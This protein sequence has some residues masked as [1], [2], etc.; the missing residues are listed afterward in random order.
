[1][2]P[3]HA[4][5][6]ARVALFALLLAPALASA[7]ARG[8]VASAG[9]GALGPAV[10]TVGVGVL[11]GLDIPPSGR[12]VGPRFTGELMFGVSDMTPQLRADL[13]ARLS[14]AYHNANFGSEWL[15]DVVP[16]LRL[17][18]SATPRLAVY[19]DLGIGLAVIRSNFD[20]FGVSTTDTVAAFQ[21]GLP[22]VS[23]AL[24]PTLNLLAEIRFNIYTGGHGTFIALP[25]L[26]FQWH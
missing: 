23:Y 24:S 12:D 1:M 6:L 7:Q 19:A 10:D 21:F 4:H 5:A 22:G 14:F 8:R 18:L 15:L 26:G 11:A 25:T 13:G 3:R 17:A 16:D 20:V 2:T 9:G